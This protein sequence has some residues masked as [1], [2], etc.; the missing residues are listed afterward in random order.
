MNPRYLGVTTNS[1][2]YIGCSFCPQ[3]VF[4]RTYHG[5]SYLT[6]ENFK[7]ALGHTPRY[8]NI[9]F[10]GFSE[11]FLNPDCLSM[12]EYAL[13]KGY[14]VDV[15][16]TLVGLKLKAV[17]RLANC[18]LAG[19][20]LHLPD[21]LGNAKIPI[22]SEYQQVLTKVLTSIKVDQFVV[23]NERFTSNL[24][25]GNLPDARK[26]HKYGWFICQSLVRPDCILL[27]NCD[28]V[29]CCNDWGLKHVLGNLLE[30]DYEDIAYSE[31][32]RKIASNRFRLNGKTLCRN[33]LYASNP[34]KYFIRRTV[35]WGAKRIG[36]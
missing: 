9:G 15:A 17:P 4:K 7:L 1:H 31:E 16:S 19:F 32:F 21:N 13:Q 22:T 35:L 24:R 36:G 5:E 33:C 18:K 34:L 26:I 2:C 29:L 20:V 12:I 8:V 14:H 30:Q 28:V 27:P 11:P 3:P 23:M 25:A 6:L 10:S